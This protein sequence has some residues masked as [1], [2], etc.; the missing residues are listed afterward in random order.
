MRMSAAESTALCS[1]DPTA[2]TSED[3]LTRYSSYNCTLVQSIVRTENLLRRF[4]DR[5]T[6]P[7]I[8]LLSCFSVQTFVR[9]ANYHCRSWDHKIIEPIKTH[10]PLTGLLTFSCRDSVHLNNCHRLMTRHRKLVD[11]RPLSNYFYLGLQFTWTKM[12]QNYSML[13]LFYFQPISMTSSISLH[14]SAS[15]GGSS[16]RFHRFTSLFVRSK[17]QAC[18]CQHVVLERIKNY[19]FTM[20]RSNKATLV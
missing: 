10:S 5:L 16:A 11:R 3:T 1:L 2:L 6:L 19:M 7:P 12:T 4:C 15:D 13:Q 17:L 14:Y 18:L 9:K 20:S 8:F